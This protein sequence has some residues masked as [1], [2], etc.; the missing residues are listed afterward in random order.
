[1]SKESK[2]IK[3]ESNRTHDIK[4]GMVEGQ[5]RYII[6]LV[7]EG[8]DVYTLFFFFPYIYIYRKAWMLAF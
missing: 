2:K 7:F 6:S 4:V 8:C 1:L 3:F 5:N